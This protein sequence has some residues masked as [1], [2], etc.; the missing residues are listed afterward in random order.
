MVGLP[1]RIKQV[2][3]AARL[4]QEAFAKAIGDHEGVKVSRGAVGNWELGGGISRAHLTAISTLFNVSL[5]W[6]EHGPGTVPKTEHATTKMSQSEKLGPVADV[7]TKS[8]IANA[9]LGEAVSLTTTI[10]VYGQAMGGKYGEFVLNGNKVAD[11][12]APASLQG[13]VGAY[14]VY[15]AGSSMEERY[16]AGEVAYVHPGLPVKKNDFVVAQIATEEGAAPLAFV[17]RF[18]SF[19]DRR[20]KLQQLNPKKFIEFPRRLVVSVHRI[21]MAGEG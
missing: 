3:K 4:S 5:D 12:L 1:D 20:L 10:P 13:V 15:I 21:L 8:L 14:A 17:K 7:S 6:L 18:I 19:D 2:R 16:F 9:R 11:V